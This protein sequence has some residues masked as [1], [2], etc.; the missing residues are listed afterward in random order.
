MNTIRKFIVSPKGNATAVA[1]L[2]FLVYL[3]TLA[4][5]VTFID[6][7]ELAAVACTLGIAH[8]T[9]YPLFTLLGWFFSRL[10]IA[11]EEIVR[12]N[13]MAAIFC[14]AGVFVFYH[15]MHFVLNGIFS[16]STVLKLKKKEQFSLGTRV[17]SAGASL[18]L[19][20]SET[21]WMQGVAIEVYSLHVLFLSLLTF[22]FLKAVFSDEWS[23]NEEPASSNGWWYAFAFLLGL[24]F[25]NHMTTI[26]LAPGFLFLYFATQ[27][28]AIDSWKKILR[29]ALPFGA[30]FSVYLYLPL[31]AAMGTS[32]N[33]GNPVTF[34]KFLWHWTGKQYRVWIFSSTE[35]A[36]RQ[37][38][39]F[40][41]ALPEEFAYIGLA[42]ALT[43][44][45]FLWRAHVKL[46]IT[47]VLLFFGCVFYSINYDI[48][49]IDSYF[50][51]AYWCVAFA[52]GIGLLALY[53]W[54]ADRLGTVPL[55]A[56][57][58]AL[59]LLPLAIHFEKVDESKNHLV[60]DYTMNMFS[61]LQPNALVF[62]FQWDYWVSSSFYYQ[63]VKN[64]RPDITVVDK[65]LLRR[66]WYFVE[67][68]RRY[69]L[70]ISGS[71]KEVDAFLSELHKFE[72]ELPYDAGTIQSR[73]VEM[74]QSFITRSIG[75]RPVYVT[76]EIEPEFTAGLQRVPE[77]LAFRV[78]NDTLGHTMR[79][80]P[81]TFRSFE[82]QGRLEDA[83]VNMY[84]SAST[85]QGVYWLQ[86]GNV[87][88]AK[89][90]LR[91]AMK[92]NPSAP[93][94][95]NLLIRLEALK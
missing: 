86:S 52:A 28:F 5:S 55:V 7:G 71:R 3:K 27:G 20:F 49:D 12:L 84:A 90:A 1:L 29:L 65:E 11:A 80:V 14:A 62:S 41:Q 42:L 9:G 82:R 56:L 38:K 91:E 79:S 54:L 19:A 61:S 25:T 36:G 72:H 89:S 2:S 78:Y 70:L 46:T 26:L 43:G 15:V 34:E 18:L 57:L 6:S 37:F 81:M 75:I 67:L 45:V 39:Y 22:A 68:E 30:G 17:A 8:P 59:G 63:L 76:T 83:L 32:L 40:M 50:L 35:A 60:E 87:D 92:F 74:I 47:L 53:R 4:P 85:T 23:A 58:L 66:S 51:L 10:P 21:Y 13:I 16:R 31:R 93:D 33:W 77:G 94:A 69:P 95:R 64:I 73:Y 44:I 48:H 88:S 24:S